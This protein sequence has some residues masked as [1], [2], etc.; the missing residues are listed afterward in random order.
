MCYGHC[1]RP[2]PHK[3][4]LW[5]PPSLWWRLPALLA[6]L[7]GDG[8]NGDYDGHPLTKGSSGPFPGLGRQ[9]KGSAQRRDLRRHVLA[10]EQQTLAD[11]QAECPPPLRLPREPRFPAQRRGSPSP[12]VLR[13]RSASARPHASGPPARGAD[14]SR[15]WRRRR[16]RAAWKSRCSWR[17]RRAW[18]A[19]RRRRRSSRCAQRRG[20]LIGN[21]EGI[22]HNTV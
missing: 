15:S 5:A 12:L 19:R 7:F 17:R 22:I 11:L 10:A 18:W 20:K 6:A 4:F 9:L 8:H 2:C 1:Y 16:R 14:S 3:A 21:R 13:P